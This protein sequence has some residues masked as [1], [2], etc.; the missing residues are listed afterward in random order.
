MA[1]FCPVTQDCDLIGTL[2]VVY[3]AA[4]HFVKYFGVF[5]GILTAPKQAH[6]K[7]GK[8]WWKKSQCAILN[9][10]N[11]LLGQPKSIGRAKLIGSTKELA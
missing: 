8:R 9:A 6:L 4:D 10:E 2:S 3:N 7:I 1:V 11:N 5:S